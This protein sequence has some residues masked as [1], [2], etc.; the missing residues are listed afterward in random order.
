MRRPILAV[1]LLPLLLIPGCRLA[2]DDESATQPAVTQPEPAPAPPR[3]VSVPSVGFQRFDPAVLERYRLDPAWRTAAES[4]RLGRLQSGAAPQSGAPLPPA[5]TE[6]P[7]APPT[8]TTAPPDDEDRILAAQVL[9]DRARFSPGVIDGRWGQNTEK[10]LYWLQ[11]AR[12][13]PPT[14]VLDDAT[15]AELERSAAGEPVVE[16]EVT[17]ADLEGPFTEVPEDVYEQAELEC[18]CYA[19]PAEALAE[20]YH[21]TP[22]LLAELNPEADLDA[23]TAGTRLQVPNVEPLDAANRQRAAGGEQ[24]AQL[25]VS[26]RGFY[27]QAVNAQGHVL[28]HFPSTVG[29]KYDPSPDGAFKVTGVAFTPTFHYQPTLFHEV[30]DENPEAQLPAGPNAPVGLVWIDLSKPHHGIHGT[31]VPET[32]GYTSSHGCIRLTNWD[33]LFLARRVKPGVPVRFRD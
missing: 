26:K 27:T 33:A 2:D 24:I 15:F 32:I 31:A 12:G 14:G 21:T 10:A 1:L 13:L 17:A 6:P 3:Q 18:L 8:P 20:R 4:D 9:L 28:F 7:P 25:L 5:T 19:S 22:E 16:V 29:S 30:P 11:F 23:L